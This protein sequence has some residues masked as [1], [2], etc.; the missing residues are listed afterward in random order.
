MRAVAITTPQGIDALGF[1]ERPDPSPGHR[2]VVVKVRAVS[3][4]YRDLATIKSAGQRNLKLPLIPCSDGAGD[5]IEVGPGVTRVKKGDRVASIFFQAWLAGDL[6]PAQRQSALGGAIDG[7]LAE[8][9]VLSEDGLVHVPEHLSYEEAATLP[10][11][12]VTA[13]QALVTRGALKAGDSVL[14]QGTGG[15][16]IFGLQFGVMHGARVIV[17]SSSDEKLARAQKLGAANLINYKTTPDW[18]QRVLE[19]TGGEGVDHVVEVAGTIDKSLGAVRVGG[20]VNLIGALTGNRQADLGNMVAKQA[21][22]Q[23]I[24]VGSREMFETMNR[25]I[26]LHR[27][28]PVIDKVFP[29]QEARQALKYIESGAHFGK[30]VISI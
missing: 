7:M 3:L 1:I 19:F 11:A 16:S 26:A 2:Q 10:C 28:K 5:V 4:N 23:G 21:R 22:L 20:F 24:Y 8:Q 9:V 14:V 13:W 17:T 15:V 30:I 18:E 27:M 6:T 29:F 12:A 25:A